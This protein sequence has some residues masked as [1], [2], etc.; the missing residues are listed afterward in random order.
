MSDSRSEL[1]VV[2]VTCDIDIDS[3]LP[4]RLMAVPTPE[5]SCVLGLGRAK[6]Q[7]A[8]VMLALPTTARIFQSHSLQISGHTSRERP[9]QLPPT[10]DWSKVKW[11][12][13]FH[14][15]HRTSTSE[16]LTIKWSI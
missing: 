8:A 1:V 11:H 5:R 2:K 10:P 16:K 3:S 14:L 15:S 7:L 9:R 12:K 13:T 6:R 4:E